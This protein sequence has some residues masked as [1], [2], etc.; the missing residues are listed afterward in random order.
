VTNNKITNGKPST[1]GFGSRGIQVEDSQLVTVSDNEIKD[2]DR[3][4][5]AS[6]ALRARLRTTPCCAR[7]SL[8]YSSPILEGPSKRMGSFLRP[9]L[10]LTGPLE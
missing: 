2:M 10:P 1:D 3:S 5:F 7:L 9:S 8:G 6:C 4:G